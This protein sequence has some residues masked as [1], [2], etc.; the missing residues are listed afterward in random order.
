MY[1]YENHLGG[2]YINDRYF[3]DEELYCEECGDS[4][5]CIGRA[6]NRKQATKLMQGYLENNDNVPEDFIEHFVEQNWKG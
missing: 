5:Y 4:D 6:D 2:F 1:I 3:S